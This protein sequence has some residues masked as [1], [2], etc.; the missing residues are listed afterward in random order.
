M[1]L[2]ARVGFVGW[3]FLGVVLVDRM[4][5]VGLPSSLAAPVVV[6]CLLLVGRA[7]HKARLARRRLADPL[8][9]DDDETH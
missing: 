8:P 5:E 3:P 9:R 1:Y 2:W 7:V 4:L 6:A